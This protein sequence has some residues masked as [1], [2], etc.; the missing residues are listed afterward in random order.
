M[1]SNDS[2]NFERAYLIFDAI[3]YVYTKFGF[4]GNS[5][6]TTNLSRRN[7]MVNAFQR[8][9]L[10]LETSYIEGENG[11]ISYRLEFKPDQLLT[12]AQ[13]T[14]FLV[15]SV[16]IWLDEDLLPTSTAPENTRELPDTGN[17]IPLIYVPYA[18]FGKKFDHVFLS[19]TK[20]GS[21]LTV[22]D[23]LNS[24]RPLLASADTSK[25]PKRRQF[26]TTLVSKGEDHF[27]Y[28]IYQTY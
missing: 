21:A 23:V 4:D 20:K 22:L 28:K 3:Q 1:N 24:M 12:A 13:N 6:Y 16:D 25:F 26:D 18:E 15:P 5:H 17:E 11:I 10:S 7:A 8:A 19:A 9:G 27:M 2:E 14:K